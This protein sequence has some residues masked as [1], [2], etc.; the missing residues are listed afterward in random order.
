MTKLLHF[1]GYYIHHSE[2]PRLSHNP[3]KN[4][5]AHLKYRDGVSSI[6]Y[7]VIIILVIYT[8]LS[9]KATLQGAQ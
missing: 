5:H 1:Y 2:S 4:I 9:C 6:K 3:L 7:Q 8:P